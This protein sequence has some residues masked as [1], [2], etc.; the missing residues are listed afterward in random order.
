MKEDL[1]TPE[2]AL[3]ELENKKKQ[4]EMLNEAANSRNPY[5]DPNRSTVD[6]V[7]KMERL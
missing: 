1:I 4:E 5:N 7:E 2:N 3:R 6:I